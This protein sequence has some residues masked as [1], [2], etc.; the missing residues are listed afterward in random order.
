MEKHLSLYKILLSLIGFIFLWTIVTDAWSYS[1]YF[2][3]FRNGNYI[4]AYLSRLIW[5]L[6]AVLLIIRHSN[7]LY[8]SKREL[9]SRPH[10]DKPLMIVLIV[11]SVYVII[12]M[13]FSHKN[14]WLNGK[15]NPPLEFIKLIVVGC[16]EETVFRGWGYNALAKV[17]SDSK[18]IIISTAFF[19]MLHWPAY[20]I[21]LYRFGTFDFSGIIGQSFAA[22]AWGIICCWLIKK[23]KT[24]WNPVIA[25]AV[26]DIMYVL[27]VG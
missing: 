21:K 19:I 7:S 6:P 22:L 5:V 24:L 2:F 3:N 10:F 13:L 26:Y 4:Y 17:T 8:F 27:L 25:H 12:M 11:S 18:A 14:F 20:F 16:V 9:F 1:D 15:V 23:G